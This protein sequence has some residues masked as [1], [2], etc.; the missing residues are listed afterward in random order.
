MYSNIEKNIKRGGTTACQ[1][2]SVPLLFKME[3]SS[4]PSLHLLYLGQ[5][6]QQMR[7]NISI[8]L[9]VSC[10]PVGSHGLGLLT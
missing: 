2:L 10:I 9:L 6:L 5:L 3:T 4:N 8:N 1:S 7:H